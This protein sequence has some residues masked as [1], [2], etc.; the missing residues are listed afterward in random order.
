ML[1]K[2]TLLNNNQVQF[3]ELFNKND[4]YNFEIYALPRNTQQKPSFMQN[5]TTK[6]IGIYLVYYHNIPH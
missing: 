1:E 6:P 5:I 3:H 2:I 4:F